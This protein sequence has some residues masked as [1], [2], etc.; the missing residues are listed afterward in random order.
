MSQLFTNRRFGAAALLAL[1]LT[2]TVGPAVAAD[3]K[4]EHVM[5]IGTVG[6]GEGQFKYVEDFAFSKEGHL[7]ATDAAHAYVQVFDKTS[8]KFIA[9]F[10]GKGEKDEHLDKP[11]G[12]RSIPK[13]ISSLPIT[14][15]VS[16]R[17]TTRAT[18][19]C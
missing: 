11:E 18:S 10:G 1:G 19:G 8:G 4:F 12:S 16:S 13:A 7:L 5:N 15:P 2:A 17:S 3:L 6:T 9:R 14:T